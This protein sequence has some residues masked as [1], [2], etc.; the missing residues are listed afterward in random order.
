M[1]ENYLLT[2]EEIGISS[3]TEV[4][5][6]VK[7][8]PIQQV[9]SELKNPIRDGVEYDAVLV[10]VD[11][12][13]IKGIPVLCY[14]YSVN[15]YEVSD[16]YF[17]SDNSTRLSVKRLTRTLKKFGFEL[18]V[19][20]AVNG[21]ESIMDYTKHLIGSKVKLIQK[22]RNDGKEDYFN[23]EIVEVVKKSTE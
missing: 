16:M 3:S 19:E 11:T 14:K 12:L 1:M 8:N 15:D 20:T 5:E 9:I 22:T 10:C 6:E 17:F 23:Y 18:K 7:L 4:K 21:I 2:E 13:V